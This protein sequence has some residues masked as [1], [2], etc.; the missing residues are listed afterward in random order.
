MALIK[1]E[2]YERAKEGL[3]MD[4]VILL[5]NLILIAIVGQ[6]LWNNA[7]VPLVPSLAKC[8]NPLHILGTSALVSMMIM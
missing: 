1:R 3:V 5:L 7:A 6:L 2:N 8:K 4:L